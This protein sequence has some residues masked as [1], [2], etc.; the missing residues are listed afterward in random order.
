MPTKRAAKTVKPVEES[1]APRRGVVADIG[2]TDEPES[3]YL[4]PMPEPEPDANFVPAADGWYTAALTDGER[5]M[6]AVSRGGTTFVLHRPS[7]GCRDVP[8]EHVTRGY[9][10]D[11]KAVT[12]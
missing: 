5:V 4:T 2:E 9:F 11:W 10:T 1:P 8:A 3:G 12:L 6:V 7:G